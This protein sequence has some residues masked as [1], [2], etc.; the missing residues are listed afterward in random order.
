MMLN[1]SGMLKGLRRVISHIKV[2]RL[3][4]I[5]VEV[6]MRLGKERFKSRRLILKQSRCACLQLAS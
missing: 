3:V 2:S 1:M 4:A 5:E 6:E